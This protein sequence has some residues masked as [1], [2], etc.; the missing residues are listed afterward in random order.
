MLAQHVDLYAVPV[1]Q[2]AGDMVAHVR[3]EAAQRIDEQRGRRLAVHIEV[4]PD[5]HLLAVAHGVQKALRRRA[6]VGQVVG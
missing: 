2:P 6:E 3:A 5:E 1:L 4:A